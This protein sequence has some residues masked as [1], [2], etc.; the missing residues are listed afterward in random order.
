MMSNEF[1]AFWFCSLL[2]FVLYLLQLLPVRT[3]TLHP[4]HLLAPLL[5]VI[6]AHS[7]RVGPGCAYLMH[8][9]ARM[10]TIHISSIMTWR[11]GLDAKVFVQECDGWGLC[12]HTLGWIR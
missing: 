11:N 12:F 8:K 6:G 4:Q 9:D 7:S 5:I 2:L 10:D 3:P 1:F